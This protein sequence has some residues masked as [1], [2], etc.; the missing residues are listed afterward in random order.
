M[1]NTPEMSRKLALPLNDTMRDAWIELV[2]RGQDA[3]DVTKAKRQPWRMT[4]RAAERAVALGRPGHVIAAYYHGVA[5]HVE[6]TINGHPVCFIEATLAEEQANHAL[7]EVQVVMGT[8]PSVPHLLEAK[9]RCR[10]QVAATVKLMSAADRR[11]A[12]AGHTGIKR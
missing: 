4:L 12:E 3:Y 2:G 6:A 8:K 11:L 1:I 5:A 7:N 9:K 10:E